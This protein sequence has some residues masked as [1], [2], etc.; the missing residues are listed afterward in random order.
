MYTQAEWEKI[1]KAVQT[2]LQPLPEIRSKEEL[3]QV[4]EQLISATTTALDL[5]VPSANPSPYSKRWFNPELK[6]QQR[7]INQVR[8]RWQESCAARESYH[9]YTMALFTEMRL[10]RRAWTR[11]IEKAKATHWR[12]FL[13]NAA[14]RHL[15]KAA[16]YINSQESYGNIPPLK[17]ATGD[18]SDNRDKAKLLIDT[19]PQD[20]RPC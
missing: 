4:A 6:A 20:S 15:W 8:R 2:I 12:E 18:V 13:D 10:K 7:K 19:L 14:K 1:G 5:H 17:A 3:K 11:A 16:S 9:P